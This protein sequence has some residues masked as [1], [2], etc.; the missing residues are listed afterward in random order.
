[1]LSPFHYYGITDI[2]VGGAIIDDK[3]DFNRIMSEE[4]IERIKLK[5]LNCM[6][7]TMGK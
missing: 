2:T 5:K 7:V 6:D 3:A 1:M 4:R